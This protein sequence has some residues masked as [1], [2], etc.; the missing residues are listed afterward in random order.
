VDQQRSITLNAKP[1]PV[2]FE[3]AETAVVVVDMQNDFGA[4]D[5]M[6]ARA[7][8]D[9]SAIQAAVAPTARVLK[10]ARRIGLKVVYLKM[11]FKDDLSDAGV[12][13][14][15]NWLVHSRMHVGDPVVAPDGTPSRILI[16]D[17]WNTDI[18][19]ELIPE[20]GDDVICKHRFSGFFET[21][22]HVRLQA[23]GIR[24][25]VFTGCTTSVCVESTFR[26]AMFRDYRCILLEDCTAEPIGNSLARSNHDASLL[27]LEV[28][29]GSI[30]TSSA[31]LAAVSPVDESA[32]AR[33]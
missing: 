4:P 15:P 2:T 11:A 16:R 19:D 9:I 13:D 10:A 1:A 20:P 31:V 24:S 14:S 30:S 18:V 12:P 22:F 8:I 3:V 29:F 17:T 7:G 25:L 33:S 32:Q 23:A 26:D 6:F 28:L 27:V 5:G 21:D